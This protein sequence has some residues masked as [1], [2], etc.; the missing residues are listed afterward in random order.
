MN[1]KLGLYGLIALFGQFP[2][3]EHHADITFV[4]FQ[5]FFGDAVVFGDLPIATTSTFGTPL[6]TNWSNLIRT[7]VIGIGNAIFV[8]INYLYRRYHFVFTT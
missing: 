3:V 2:S 4:S 5:V 7:I 1:L 6:I 8:G